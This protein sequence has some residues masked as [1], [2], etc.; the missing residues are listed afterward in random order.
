MGSPPPMRGKAL[1]PAELEARARITPAHA[2]KSSAP[3]PRPAG[4]EDHPRPCGEK[5]TIRI[6]YVLDAGSP[7]P[8]RGKG[9][10]TPFCRFHPRI[11][12]AHAGKSMFPE[13][14]NEVR[15]DHP[16][17]CGEKCASL[18]S[19]MC[20]KGSPP[21]M[22]GKG[23]RS[24][25][26]SRN[27]RITPAHAGKRYPQTAIF[28][29]PWDHPRPCGEKTLRTRHPPR[30]TG[31]PPPMRGKERR[32]IAGYA[33]TGITPAHAGKSGVVV[34]VLLDSQDHPRPCGEKGAQI[35]EFRQAAGSPPPMR[36]K[37]T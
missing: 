7:P 32:Y 1:L 31:S 13:R 29:Y 28:L 2:G 34:L 4:R 35:L 30:C 26:C 20:G 9:P 3:V 24:W 21:P 27:L 5:L 15:Q 10:Y 33:R 25:T 6:G 16:R 22:R 36:G 11:T 12:P 17:P 14:L 23:W 37:G 18:S 19:C 8:M